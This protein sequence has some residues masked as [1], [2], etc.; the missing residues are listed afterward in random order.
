[1]RSPAEHRRGNEPG[2]ERDRY[3][4]EAVERRI[5]EREAMQVPLEPF[6]LEVQSYRVLAEQL[7]LAEQIDTRVERPNRDVG[8]QLD[9]G[10][11]QALADEADPEVV[12][13]VE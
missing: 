11:E 4:H 6:A 5:A 1:M 8:R 3:G 9:G 13:N 10:A 7:L 12:L 2:R